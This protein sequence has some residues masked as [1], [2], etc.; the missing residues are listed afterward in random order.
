MPDPKAR[1]TVYKDCFVLDVTVSDGASVRVGDLIAVLDSEDEDRV[2]DRISLA[3]SFIDLQQKSISDPQVAIR[4]D[5]LKSTA[6]VARAY[7]DYANLKVRS[8]KDQV[9]VGEALNVDVQQG[10]AAVIRA[11]AE[12]D[13][14]TAAVTLFEFNI[15]QAKTKLAL[16][17]TELPKETAAANARKKRVSVHSPVD[18][19]IKLLCY[20][21]SFVKR[22]DML[23][24][25]F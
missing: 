20:K 23:A 18:G 16:I 7:L 12:L 4:R 9:L 5:I 13:R 24:A 2:L 21:G 6:D 22:G 11:S 8:L 25:V 14:A 10:T 19:R 17:Q 15:E 1:I 3:N